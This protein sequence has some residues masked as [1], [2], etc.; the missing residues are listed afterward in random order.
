METTS[1]KEL[2]ERKIVA[3]VNVQY[4]EKYGFADSEDYF[5]KAG[6]CRTGVP[7]YQ[8]SILMTSFTI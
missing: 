4:A 5:Y 1:E 2:S 7:I 6:R 3:G 8:K